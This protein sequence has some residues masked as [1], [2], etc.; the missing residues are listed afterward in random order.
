MNFQTNGGQQVALTGCWKSEETPAVGTV[1]SLTGSDRPQSAALKKMLT[2]LTIWFWVKKICHS[3]TEQSVKSCAR[4]ELGQDEIMKLPPWV[5]LLPF[6]G[7]QH[8]TQ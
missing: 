4:Q 7:T 6:I 5:W 2:W 8:N 3:L 1:N